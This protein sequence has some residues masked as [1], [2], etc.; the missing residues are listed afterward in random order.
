MI[1]FKYFKRNFLSCASSKNKLSWSIKENKLSF[2]DANVQN[3][4]S[5]TSADGKLHK[6]SIDSD[7]RFSAFVSKKEQKIVN[8]RIFY[9]LIFPNDNIKN[10]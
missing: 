10:R 6:K 4:F 5:F 9:T 2:Y 8:I 1:A 3:Y 7:E